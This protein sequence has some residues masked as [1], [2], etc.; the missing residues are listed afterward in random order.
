MATSE[1]GFTLHP[2]LAADCITVTDLPLCRVLLL[3][4]S[5]FPWLV[6]VPRRANITEAYQLNADE[7]TVLWQEVTGC[8]EALMGH[9]GGDKLNIGALGNIVPQLHVH[10]IVRF[11][12][13][14]AWPGPVWGV[15]KAEAHA[16]AKLA[17]L[18]QRYA[19][20][21]SAADQEK[22]NS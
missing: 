11:Q 4:D 6:L 14:A 5:R 19:K 18:V 8:G 21:L 10:V 7:Q 15:G 9:H 3:N 12:N 1:Q 22:A 13:D 17:T 20:L 2:Q 16:P